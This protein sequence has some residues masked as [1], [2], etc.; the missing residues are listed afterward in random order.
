M[1][2]FLFIKYNWFVHV[3]C[4]GGGQA[5]IHD[6]NSIWIYY[7]QGISINVQFLM[8]LNYN[9]SYMKGRKNQIYNL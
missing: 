8:I 1:Q 9:T 3:P 6:E 2:V 7:V 4:Q 5:E